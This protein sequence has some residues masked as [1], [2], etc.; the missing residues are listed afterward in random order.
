MAGSLMIA[1]ELMGGPFDGQTIRI[2]N[3]TKTIEM[4]SNIS[5]E[6]FME[7]DFSVKEIEEIPTKICIYQMNDEGKYWFKEER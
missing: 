7:D 2:P 4:V 6:V 3:D 5:L 1:V